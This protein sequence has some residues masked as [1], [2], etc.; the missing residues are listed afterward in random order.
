METNEHWFS[1]SLWNEFRAEGFCLEFGCEVLKWSKG[2]K[3]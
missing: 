3:E 1:F 2:K